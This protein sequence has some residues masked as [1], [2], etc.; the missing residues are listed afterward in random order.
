MQRPRV[1][2]TLIEL[3]V[4]IA[5]IAALAGMLMPVLGQVREQARASTCRSNLRQAGLGVIAYAGD[6][7]GVLPLSYCETG[8]TPAEWGTGG[9]RGSWGD[10]QAVG[11]YL[12]GSAVASGAF[13]SP[14][15]R[16]G[17]LNCP[18]DRR[19][20]G[21]IAIPGSWLTTMSYGLNFQICPYVISPGTMANWGKLSSL[22]R[23]RGTAA[24]A[25]A[26]DTMEARWYTY[27]VAPPAVS[28]VYVDQA[29][30][31][32][33]WVFGYQPSEMMRRH[34]RGSNLLFVDGHAGFSSTLPAE[35]GARTAFVR[36]IDV[37]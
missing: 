34:G 27:N 21:R 16:T 35:V 3:L 25:L 13:P 18:A 14:S 8:Y 36:L 20:A 11:G 31:T 15:R 24:M 30:A 33:Q 1:G 29:T 22:A 19:D 32:I 12:D 6:W 9:A 26:T 5:I 23:L 7:E 4:V 28:L 2:F 17:I 10:P 37:P